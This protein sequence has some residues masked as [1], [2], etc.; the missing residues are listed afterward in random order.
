MSDTKMLQLVLDKVTSLEKKV[1][2]GFKSV[3]LRF[4]GVDKRIDKLGLQIASLEDDAPT[5]EEFEG[6]EKK[7][8]KIQKR[9]ALG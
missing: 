8:V 1:D 3:D 7:V 5:M 4:D 6:L 9:L 2:T